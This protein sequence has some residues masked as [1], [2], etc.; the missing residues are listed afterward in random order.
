M[1]GSGVNAGNVAD[2]A[3][4]T[5]AIEFH[6]SARIRVPGKMTYQNPLMNETSESISVDGDEVR[7]IIEQLSLLHR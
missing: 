5:G 6:T 7:K 2:L 1:P 3:E 4:N